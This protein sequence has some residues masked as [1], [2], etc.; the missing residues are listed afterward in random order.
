MWQGDQREAGRDGAGKGS[1]GVNSRRD[2][3]V[4]SGD[5]VLPEEGETV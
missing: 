3:R 2:G 4:T 1:G 5:Q